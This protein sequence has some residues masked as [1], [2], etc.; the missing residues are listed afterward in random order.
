MPSVLIFGGSGK[1][2]KLITASLVK[3]DYRVYSVIRREDHVPELRELGATP[4]MQS[5]EDSTVAELTATIESC[6]PDLVIFAAGAGLRGFQDPS[7]STLV[8]RDTAIRV[9]DAMADANCTKRLLTL[10]T[11][12]A[13]N[14]DKPSPTWYSEE[15]RESSAEL[16]AVVPT[17]MNAK[18]EADQ[19][20]VEQNARRGL[21]YTI[22]RHTW[23]GDEEP[24]GKV[25]AGWAGFSPKVSRKEVA[26][27]FV[28]CIENPATIGCVFEV[29]GGEVPIKEAVQRVA[30]EKVN[31]FG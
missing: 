27:V 4:I 5:L 22:I 25:K 21:E 2:A 3:Q 13:R 16:W 28:A 12:D 29:S 9:F 11:I 20:L 18:F 10:S 30:E 8:D 14:R 17:Y 6:T 19:D 15:D 7:L 24:T 26:D 23:Y 1:V 31:T